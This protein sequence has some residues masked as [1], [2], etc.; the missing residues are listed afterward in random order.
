MIK[1]EN[2]PR[3]ILIRQIILRKQKS[4]MLEIRQDRIKLQR[5]KARLLQHCT[6]LRPAVHPAA[7]HIL[8]FP[9]RHAI[10]I[11]AVKA[12]SRIRILISAEVTQA[13]TVVQSQEQT[14][15]RT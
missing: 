10:I 3:Q 8:L 7:E 4:R 2:P 11:Y 12:L 9:V 13:E 15:I 14:T 1:R 5:G 6:H